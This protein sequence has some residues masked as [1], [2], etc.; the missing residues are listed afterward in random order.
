MHG[1]NSDKWFFVAKDTYIF[2]NQHISD[3][4]Y[5]AIGKHFNGNPYNMEN[6][7]LVKHGSSVIDDLPERTF[8]QRLGYCPDRHCP[9]PAVLWVYQ[10]GYRPVREEP[11]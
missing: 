9:D 10:R 8:E 3:G 11:G 1:N 6:D 5:E 7:T 4:T 2:H